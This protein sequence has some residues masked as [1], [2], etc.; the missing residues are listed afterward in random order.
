MPRDL[1]A[2]I[3]S[4]DIQ[5]AHGEG[6]GSRAIPSTPFVKDISDVRAESL[7]IGWCKRP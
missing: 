5:L 6:P 1:K 7:S 3:P 2:G 4:L